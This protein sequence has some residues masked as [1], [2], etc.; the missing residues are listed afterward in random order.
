[1]KEYSTGLAIFVELQN[2]K[3]FMVT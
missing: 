2:G 1:M 3:W